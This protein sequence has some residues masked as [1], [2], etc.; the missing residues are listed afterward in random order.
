MVG[1]DGLAGSDTFIPPTGFFVARLMVAGRMVVATEGVTNQD[2][3]AALGIEGAIGFI[4]QLI[5][6]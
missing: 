4:N 2:G 1:V 3:I 6:V 5:A